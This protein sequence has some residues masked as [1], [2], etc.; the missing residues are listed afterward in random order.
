MSDSD[1]NIYALEN[2]HV[3]QEDETNQDDTRS[4]SG[5]LITNYPFNLNPAWYT[6]QEEDEDDG[7]DV[8]AASQ[9]VFD[10]DLPTTHKVFITLIFQTELKIKF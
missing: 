2:G 10:R 7:E 1:E 8:A 5:K 6:E 4:L 9:G 3:P